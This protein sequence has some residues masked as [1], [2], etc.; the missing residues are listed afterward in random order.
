MILCDHESRFAASPPLWVLLPLALLKA[1]NKKAQSRGHADRRRREKKGSMKISPAM[2]VP[3]RIFSKLRVHLLVGTW[4]RTWAGSQ[5][6]GVRLRGRPRRTAATAL[7]HH[8]HP[9][10]A[11]SASTYRC[12]FPNRTLT[13]E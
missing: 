7:N 4:A 3:S 8:G 10:A 12:M 9:A 2:R 5:A 13:P 6:P 1:R 11:C